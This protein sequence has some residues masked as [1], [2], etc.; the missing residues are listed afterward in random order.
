MKTK[1]LKLTLLAAFAS[2]IIIF[3]FGS[4][5]TTAPFLSSSV[6][7]AAT[8]TVKVTKDKNKNYSIQ[9]KFK[10]LAPS[11]RLTP[12]KNTYVVW[13]IT[14]DNVTKN[15]GQIKV[16]NSLNASFETVSTFKPKQI[17]VTAEDDPTVFYPSNSETVL[18][19]DYLK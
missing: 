3:T 19:T 14:D 7:P 12:P 5:A 11:E 8:G 10:N 15:I 16:T 2:V 6:V 1:N 18:I 4:C 13:M 17:L 9:I